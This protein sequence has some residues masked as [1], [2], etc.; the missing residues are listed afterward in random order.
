MHVIYKAGKSSQEKKDLGLD[1]S[2]MMSGEKIGGGGGHPEEE[3][4]VFPLVIPKI[5]S[6]TQL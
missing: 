3:E 2:Q 6:E 5:S 1:M 4:E